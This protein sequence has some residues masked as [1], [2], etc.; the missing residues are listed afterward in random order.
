M[1]LFLL[2]LPT[3]TPKSL[4]PS[5]NLQPPVTFNPRF[6]TLLLRSQYESDSRHPALKTMEQPLTCNNQNGGACRAV[7]KREAVVTT[8]SHIFCLSCAQTTGLAEAPL[9]RRRCPA[10]QS[11]LPSPDDAV[12]TRLNPTEEYKTSVLSGLDPGAILDCAG[13]AIAFWTYQITHEIAYQQY[14]AKNLTDRYTNLNA[15]MDNVVHEANTEIQTMQK[16]LEDLS[17]AHQGLQ[18]RYDELADS[19]REKSR[20]LGTIQKLYNAIKQRDQARE[21]IAPAASKDVEQTLQSLGSVR[22]SEAGFPKPDLRR[23]TQPGTNPSLPERGPHPIGA[24]HG[25]VEQLHPQQ[26]SGSSVLGTHQRGMPSARTLPVTKLPTAG[27][28]GTPLHR[29]A[30][31]THARTA[32]SRSQIPVTSTRAQFQHDQHVP[33]SSRLQSIQ[34][35]SVPVSMQSHS[36]IPSGVKNGRPGTAGSVDMNP[37][38]DQYAGKFYHTTHP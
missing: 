25:G 5:S 9:D 32:V 23:Q 10:C 37:K 26:R 21:M 16:K 34:A 14:V 7:L 6:N 33:G 13:R 15:A 17:R 8:C 31:P 35:S 24:A 2:Y 29:E 18:Q 20:K 28:S 22:R 38:F 36:A 3:Q 11:Q 4:S 1:L 19:Y 12:Q 30:L 27:V